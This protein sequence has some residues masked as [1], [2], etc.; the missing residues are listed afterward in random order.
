[1]YYIQVIIKVIIKDINPKILTEDLTD[2]LQEETTD[3]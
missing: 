3:T 2:I 1:M